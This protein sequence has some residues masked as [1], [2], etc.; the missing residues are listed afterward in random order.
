[1]F[2]I[3]MR[4][5]ID[6]DFDIIETGLEGLCHEFGFSVAFDNQDDFDA[7]MLDD[8]QSVH[9]GRISR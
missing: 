6:C 1:M 2:N 8:S 4:G 7:F 5:I 9:I 3:M